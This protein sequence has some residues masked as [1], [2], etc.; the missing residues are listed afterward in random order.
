[1][2]PAGFPQSEAILEGI[3][4]QHLHHILRFSLD[5]FN[6]VRTS[7]LELEYQIQE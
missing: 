2:I 3:P 5:L 6:A 4:H 7:P 1:V